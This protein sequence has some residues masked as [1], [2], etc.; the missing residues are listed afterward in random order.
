[1]LNAANMIF[2]VNRR[3][4]DRAAGSVDTIREDV[5]SQQSLYASYTSTQHVIVFG[6]HHE[7]YFD[8]SDL[9]AEQQIENQNLE[10]TLRFFLLSESRRTLPHPHNRLVVGSSPTG[11]T[12]TVAAALKRGLCNAN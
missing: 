6:G 5:Y 1:M 8:T 4:L 12:I 9:A 7:I 3:N 2:A 11:P 10:K